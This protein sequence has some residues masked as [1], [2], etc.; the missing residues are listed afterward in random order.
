MD[1][2]YSTFKNP[3]PNIIF[4]RT[5]TKEIENIIKSL[6]PKN[7]YGYDEISVKILKICSPFI[8]TPLNYICNRAIL[9][10]TFPSCLKY[11]VIKPLFKKGGKK[12]IKN[13]RPISL[14][15]SL[16]KV[17]EKMIYI[18]LT[19]HI[20][21][22]IY[23]LLSSMDLEVKSSTENPSFKLLNDVLQA[24]NNKSNVGGLFCD[25]EKAFDCVDHNL[26]MEKLMEL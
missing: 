7:S 19:N 13:Y 3:Y 22:I 10:G 12:D 16:S 1:Y 4:D 11:S 25:L 24:L 14:L 6:K 26:L 8:A 2:L 20:K 5:T 18:R 15:T 9:S 21:I 23:Y 17:F